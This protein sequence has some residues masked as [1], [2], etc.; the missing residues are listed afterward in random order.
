MNSWREHILKEFIPGVSR[1]TLVSDPD[2]L[3]A[4]EGIV[5]ALRE[6][7]FE[8]LE[9]EDPIAFRY[10]YESKYRSKWDS[11]EPTELV[12]A[13]RVPT[14]DL[15]TL[16]YDLL[17]AGRVLSFNLGEIF[18]NL[19]Y[20]VVES[21]DRSDL[22]ALYRA[23]LQY[24]PDN[25]GDNATKDFV[26]RH[27]F[28]I[29][30][31]LINQPS[32]LL[33]VLLRLHYKGQR[34]PSIIDER[35]IQI[36]RQN[37]SF[38]DWPLEQIIPDR[39]AFF[40]F[41]Q[42]RWP[43]FLDK[44]VADEANKIGEQSETYLR[45]QGPKEIPFDHDDIRVYID[46]L[47]LEGILSPVQ[48]PEAEKLSDKWVAVGLI[49]DPSADAQ[50]RMEGLLESMEAAIPDMESRYHDWL[51]F[52][53]RWAELI[54]LFYETGPSDNLKEKFLALRERIDIAFLSWVMKRY[55]G[56][57]NQP[58][59]PPVMLHHVPKT[60]AR[61][62]EGRNNEKVALILID[63]MSFD[64]WIVLRNAI[65]LHLPELKFRE[66]AVFAWLPT[67]TSVS[68]Q[69]A[70][71]GK[72]PIYFPESIHTTNREKDLWNS[73]WLDHGLSKVEV[74]YVKGI[75][76]GKLKLVEEIISHPRM[77]VVGIIVDKIDKIMHGMELGTAGMHNQIRQWTEQGFMVELL[78]LL[79]KH[80]FRIFL[81]SD[82][83]NIEAKGCGRPS[84]G[85]VAD[86]RGERVRIYP[87]VR[88]RRQTREKFPDAIEWPAIGLPD[89]YLP[90]IAHNRAAF[91]SE[92]ETVVAHGGITL[93]ELIVPFIH[94]DRR[95]DN[96]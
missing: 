96:G 28:G 34:I 16:P 79:I 15:T 49:T 40:S 87:D 21:L 47:F 71:S 83:G 64:E 61:S 50:R 20:P 5:A 88:L 44:V 48:H 9:F 4:E 35:F 53:P 68:R 81:T 36:V 38:N 75:R 46:N 58:P 85:S 80:E 8:M 41:L 69:S 92:G 63:G 22:D 84:E 51:S 19:S 18:P 12:V 57:H 60:L 37:K 54:T 7:G 77:R 29:A 27:V 91:V 45:F 52:A 23:Q 39:E 2:G 25:L 14:N 72:P 70:F 86:L 10:S 33:R 65:I 82:H 42:E 6:R 89:Y 93:E 66:R 95:K 94:F 26:L 56:L 13:V 67:I 11:G 76:D 74:G 43:I 17:Q 90:L 30:P 24:K 59:T 73:F 3:M 32:D 78:D 31:E 1:L 55:A 62:L